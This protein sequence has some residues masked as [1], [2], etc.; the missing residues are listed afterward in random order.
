MLDIHFLENSLTLN[1]FCLQ[2][3]DLPPAAREVLLSDREFLM[4]SIVHYETAFLNFVN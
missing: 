1:A 2:L 4:E 3:E